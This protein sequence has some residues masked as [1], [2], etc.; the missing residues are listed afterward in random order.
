MRITL[1]E[2][3]YPQPPT[4]LQTDN[5]TASG[6][7]NDTVKQRRSK[8]I[9]M[10]FYWIRDRVR[11]G[12]FFIYWRKGS[13]NLADYFTKHHAPTHHINRR[14]HILH[15]ASHNRFAMLADTENVSATKK[16]QSHTTSVS[17]EGV[18][19]SQSGS[20]VT[21]SSYRTQKSVSSQS[22][23]P[24]KFTRRLSS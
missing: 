24:H 17:C 22:A 19:I 10:R 11:Q 4:P 9:D 21:T 6:I 5:S 1:E 18:L 16:S 20:P 13:I 3:G 12:Q 23:L 14:P 2:L 8:A 15:S 7:V